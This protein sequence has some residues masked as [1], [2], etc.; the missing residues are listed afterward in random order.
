MLD[1]VLS[2]LESYFFFHSTVTLVDR[3]YYIHFIRK[4][5]LPSSKLRAWMMDYVLNIY[6]SNYSKELRNLHLFKVKCSFLKC[7][8]VTHF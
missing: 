5:S 3:Q 2:D 6:R 4:D 1:T 8:C 7:F